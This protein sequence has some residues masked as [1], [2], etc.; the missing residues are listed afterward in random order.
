M[1]LKI[2]A[3]LL[4]TLILFTACAGKTP[5]V[6]YSEP[7]SYDLTQYFT[8]GE[9][10]GI[11]IA[12]RG[13]VV[14]TQEEINDEIEYFLQYMST[15]E[16]LNEGTV[17]WGD[18]VNI[19]YI[20]RINDVA[21]EGGT[22]SGFNLT[23][24][25]GNFIEGF[26]SG[27]IGY[28]VGET[29]FVDVAFPMDYWKDEY[30]GVNAVFEVKLN[31][32]LV[33][34]KPELTDEFVKVQMIPD[35]ETAAQYKQMIE[36]QIREYKEQ[37]QNEEVRRELWGAVYSNSILIKYPEIEV[38]RYYSEFVEYYTDEAAE[39]GMTLEA[40]LNWQYGAALEEFQKDMRSYAQN[41]VH[42]DLILYS[43]AKNENLK[44]SETEYKE[45]LEKY[46]YGYYHGIPTIEEFEAYYSKDMITKELL[47]DKVFD[48]LVANAIE[49]EVEAFG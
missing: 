41:Y 47:Q 45:G 2:L 26:E 40:H 35:C 28:N 3:L 5:P 20:G 43:I 1:K 8:L 4:I 42:D 36:T 11:E 16:Q 13:I 39:N 34:I 23:I 30:A 22:D 24:G 14:V 18:T 27:L 17:G 37:T 15:T 19:D 7:Y 33:I 9:Y 32:L 12:K 48:F 31:Y 6:D 10:K 21:F 49:I 29:V 44:I 25:S 46:F 38:E